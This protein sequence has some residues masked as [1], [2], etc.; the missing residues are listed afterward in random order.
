MVASSRPMG[1]MGWILAPK[2][3]VPSVF[4]YCLPASAQGLAA[5]SSLIAV[6]TFT[7]GAKDSPPSVDW[8]KRI[9]VLISAGSLRASFQLKLIEPLAG[10]TESHWLNWS[11]CTPVGSSLTRTRVLQLAPR[12]VE[13]DTKISVPF[14]AVSSIQEQ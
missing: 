12:S 8:L 11:F 3:T 13:W 14:D 2:G 1:Q 9:S 6:V 5:L 7:L 4:P 10:S